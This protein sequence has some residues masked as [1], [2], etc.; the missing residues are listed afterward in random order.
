MTKVWRRFITDFQKPL[1][2]ALDAGDRATVKQMLSQFWKEPFT[3]GFAQGKS[4][5]D[6]LNAKFEAGNYQMANSWASKIVNV[7]EAV[8]AIN[9][10]GLERRRQSDVS[11]TDS[12]IKAIEAK[13]N[14]PFGLPELNAGLYGLEINGLSVHRKEIEGYVLAHQVMEMCDEPSICEVGSGAGHTAYFLNKFG[15]KRVYMFDLPSV[16][17]VAIWFLGRLAG[18]DAICVYGEKPSEST[19]FVFRPHYTFGQ[20][21][22]ADVRFNVLVNKNSFPEMGEEV[23]SDY[24]KNAPMYGCR[25]VYSSNYERG[26]KVGD[27]IAL[28]WKAA[29]RA[30]WR[31][32]S[33]APNWVKEGNVE[34]MFVA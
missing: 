10:Q 8:G 24:F 23:A 22:D 3:Q 30:G 11:D 20:E 18:P 32:I 19:Q 2:D 16:A 28:V 26:E 34:E 6:K 33:R 9:S 17:V 15:A 31:R 7:A 4:G 14:V 29:E 13:T 12:I 21:E 27:H 5:F 1:I 25:K